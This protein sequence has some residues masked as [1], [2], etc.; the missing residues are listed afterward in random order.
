[1]GILGLRD[2]S[3]AEFGHKL[4]HLRRQI[5]DDLFSTKPFVPAEEPESDDKII[6]NILKKIMN[7]RQEGGETSWD[8]PETSPVLPQPDHTAEDKTVP[9]IQ[10]D[11]DVFKTVVLSS[12]G[13]LTEDLTGIEQ[14]QEPGE[15]IEVSE[16]EADET[17]ILPPER[18]EPPGISDNFNHYDQDDQDMEETVILSPDHM[19]HHLKSSSKS[20]QEELPETIIISPEQGSSGYPEVP[21]GH[22]LQDFASETTEK[23]GVVPDNPMTGENKK[24]ETSEPDEFLEETILIQPGKTYAGK[25]GGK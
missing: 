4:E 1:V 15:A 16:R 5:K 6:S 22:C 24:A 7:T 20:E 25:K 12:D 9:D 11:A 8:E 18:L 14:K 13:E 3:M 2:W 21:Q 17:L 19:E 23:G 10:E